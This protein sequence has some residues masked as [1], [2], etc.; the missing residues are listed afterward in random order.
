MRKSRQRLID[1]QAAMIAY[2]ITAG[3]EAALKLF[4]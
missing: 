1:I 4:N 3:G 2:D